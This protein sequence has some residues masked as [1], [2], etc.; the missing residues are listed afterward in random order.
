MKH[1]EKVVHGTSVDNGDVPPAWTLDRPPLSVRQGESGEIQQ[2]ATGFVFVV[3]SVVA[4]IF[5]VIVGSGDTG[6][7]R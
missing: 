1:V 6:L 3:H 5:V 4:A 7:V 2:G